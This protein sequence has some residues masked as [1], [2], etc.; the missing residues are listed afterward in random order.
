M[1]VTPI[2]KILVSY[3]LGDVKPNMRICHEFQHF[4]ASNKMCITTTASAQ[5]ETTSRGRI[6]GKGREGNHSAIIARDSIGMVDN[7]MDPLQAV[8]KP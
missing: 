5:R 6:Y 4:I 1:R 8:D 7:P 3:D 2:D